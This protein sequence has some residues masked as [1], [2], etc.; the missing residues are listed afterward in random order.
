MTHACCPTCRLRFDRAAAA[1]LMACPQ[2]GGNLD[3]VSG[4]RH[5]LGFRLFGHD[6]LA[7]ALP[8][9]IAV[10]MRESDPGGSP[11]PEGLS[12]AT[13]PDGLTHG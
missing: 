2:C 6:D 9:A 12:D 8:D 7:D 5:T 11:V 4:A 10:A 1:Y 3:Q 13:P